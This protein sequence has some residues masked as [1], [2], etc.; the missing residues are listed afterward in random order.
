MI[1]D[2]KDE[3]NNDFVIHMKLLLDEMPLMDC[4]INVGFSGGEMSGK[5]GAK[6]KFT[7]VSN[8]NLIITDKI[9]NKNADKDI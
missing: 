4:D 5:L 7:P 8:F 1:V 6:Y 2:E 9:L 3:E